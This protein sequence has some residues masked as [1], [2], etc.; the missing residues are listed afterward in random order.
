MRATIVNAEI[1]STKQKSSNLL[2][3]ALRKGRDWF[4]PARPPHNP[5]PPSDRTPRILIPPLAE[6]TDGTKTKKLQSFD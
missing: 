4:S 1:N 3:E 5:E 2:I 6:I